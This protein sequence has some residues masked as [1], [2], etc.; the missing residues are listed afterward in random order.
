[1]KLISLMLPSTDPSNP[2]NTTPH[3]SQFVHIQANSDVYFYWQNDV[4]RW[5]IYDWSCDGQ[6]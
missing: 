1:M 3:E 2:D 4:P 6:G 5:Q